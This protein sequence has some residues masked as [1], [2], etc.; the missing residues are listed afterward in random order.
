MLKTLLL[1]AG[2]LGS[3]SAFAARIDPTT[4]RLPWMNAQAAGTEYVM[5]DHPHKVHVFE[6]FTISCGSC[7]ANARNVQ[8]LAREFADDDRVQFID[9]GQNSDE[10]DFRRWIAQHRPPF[11]VVKDVDQAVYHA[12]DDN[13]AVPQA[14]VVDCSGLLIDK[15]E[16]VWTAEKTAK[17][18]TAIGKALRTT[19]D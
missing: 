7:G 13:G 10:R 5:A 8:A 2:V 3:A 6:A 9:L 19:C 17:I 14:F 12:L 15:V 18:R 16:G 4:V 1:A 11:P